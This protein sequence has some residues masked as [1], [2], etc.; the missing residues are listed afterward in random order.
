MY[1]VLC[2][3]LCNRISIY[4]I[5][6]N[7]ILFYVSVLIVDGPVV[8]W[9]S[10]LMDVGLFMSYVEGRGMSAVLTGERGAVVGLVGWSDVRVFGCSRAWFGLV[11]LP[12]V[13]YIYIFYI[14]IFFV[15][16]WGLV[17]W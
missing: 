8:Q 5:L 6:S 4:L 17:G 15:F 11:L 13:I 14:F 16:V 2:I 3:S 10:G 1:Y 9:F 12:W 7:S